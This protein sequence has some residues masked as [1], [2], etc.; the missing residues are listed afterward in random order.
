[1][2]RTIVIGDV[3]GCIDELERLLRA[4]ERDA[5]TGVVLVG[6]L[7]AKGPDSRAVVGLAREIGALAVL[8]NHDEKVLRVAA[9]ENGS[10]PAVGDPLARAGGRGEHARVAAALEAG[11]LDWLRDLPRW[12]SLGPENPGGPETLVVHGGFLPGVP[13]ADQDPELLIHLRSIRPDGHP[14]KRLDGAPWGSVWHGPQHVLFGHDAVRGL[15]MH[16]FTTGLDTGCVYGGRLT[17]MVLPE[18]RLV[19]VEARRRYDRPL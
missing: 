4:C 1:M 17:A 19:S 15:Q 18:R 16:P 7:V 13:L 6:D 2:K 9:G 14:S 12:L 5:D 11:D 10:P 3:H 8:G